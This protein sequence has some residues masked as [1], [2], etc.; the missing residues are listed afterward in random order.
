MCSLG[1]EFL[2]L[3][4][5]RVRLIVWH[6]VLDNLALSVHEELSKVPRDVSAIKRAVLPHVLVSWMAVWTID[7]NLLEK[8]E[9]DVELLNEL[10]D[11]SR[12]LRLLLTEL[13]ARNSIN[14][15]AFILVIVINCFQLLVVALSQSSVGCHIDEENGL[16]ALSMFSNGA[17]AVSIDVVD[18]VV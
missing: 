6:I 15:Q 4:H 14:F 12:R 10:L 16:L 5:D 3:W 2:D 17:Q 13:I 8:R 11:F 7:F 18:L 1:E 9:N